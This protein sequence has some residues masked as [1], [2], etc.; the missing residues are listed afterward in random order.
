MKKKSISLSI[1][2]IAR[3]NNTNRKKR[4]IQFT[5]AIGEPISYPK[6][7]VLGTPFLLGSPEE[8][9]NKAFPLKGLSS[10]DELMFEV[11][12]IRS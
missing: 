5:R 2:L 7:S 8:K 1:F 9:I 3:R 12:L 6:Y 4:L 10:I 11:W